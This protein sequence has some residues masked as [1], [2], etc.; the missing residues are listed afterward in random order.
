ML[1]C[2]SVRQNLV[3]SQVVATDPLGVGKAAGGPITKPLGAGADDQS[4]LTTSVVS[5][6]VPQLGASAPSPQRRGR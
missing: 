3:R 4:L 5:R 2:A 6:A 1:P